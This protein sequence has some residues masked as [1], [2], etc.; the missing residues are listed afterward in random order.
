MTTAGRLMPTGSDV[1]GV[2]ST[3][4]PGG[5][6]VGPLAEQRGKLF[7]DLYRAV[8]MFAEA[9]DDAT[10][11]GTV[12]A[13]LR[14]PAQEDVRT[15]VIVLHDLIVQANRTAEATE[16]AFKEY[17]RTT[18]PPLLALTAVV[19]LVLIYSG[20]RKDKQLG[21]KDKQLEELMETVRQ[22]RGIVE[23]AAKEAEKEQ[24]IKDALNK[25]VAVAKDAVAYYQTNT[26]A[27]IVDVLE[28]V[29]AL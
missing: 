13:Y 27:R 21:E 18:T 22:L 11:Y 2:R 28:A 29:K 19:F 8:D 3:Y 9:Q 4:F 23:R 10:W 1:S 7:A 20:K 26:N 15:Q 6:G 14:S 24:A 25:S 17:V 12:I 16:Q 5:W